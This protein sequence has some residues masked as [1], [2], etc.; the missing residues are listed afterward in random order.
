V[1]RTCVIW[2]GSTSWE[3]SPTPPPQPALVH[4][5]T[6]GHST[7]FPLETKKKNGLEETQPMISVKT[8]LKRERVT[9]K[10]VVT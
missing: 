6:Q 2:A 9:K 1:T 5:S 3:V 8:G 10:Y 4:S 7:K